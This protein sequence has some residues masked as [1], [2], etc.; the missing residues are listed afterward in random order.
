MARI[1]IIGAMSSEVETYCETFRAKKTKIDDETTVFNKADEALYT[2]K[3]TGRDKIC[4][5]KQ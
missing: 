3:N 2:A 1:G 4:I 5:F